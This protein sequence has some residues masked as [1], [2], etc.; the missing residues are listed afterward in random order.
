MPSI[1]AA[2]SSSGIQVSAAPVNT[3]D[4]IEG[5]FAAQARNRGSG[6]V[7]MPDPFNSSNRILITA[8]A[9][10][11]A[12][13]TIYYTRLFAESGGLITYGSDFVELFRQGAGYVDRILR[14]SKPSELPVQAP[15]KFELV[16][17]LKTAKSLGLDVPQTLLAT[18]D[19]VIE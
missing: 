1:Q 2:A 17:N 3:K 14:G 15:T 5:V 8:L 11:Y 6:L 18:A 9:A 12:V 13:P 16:L 7:A 19:E 10:R 4:A